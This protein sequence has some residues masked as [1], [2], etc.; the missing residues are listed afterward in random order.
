MQNQNKI[1]RYIPAILVLIVISLIG[2]TLWLWNQQFEIIEYDALS[3]KSKPRLNELYA[4]EIFLK[5]IHQTAESHS[6]A[7]YVVDHLPPPQDIIIYTNATERLSNP[8]RREALISWVK[9]GGHLV[10][11][12]LNNKSNDPLLA[13]LGVHKYRIQDYLDEQEESKDDDKDDK[14]SEPKN[15]SDDKTK[16]LYKAPHETK[17]HEVIRE[18]QL[19]ATAR[20]PKKSNQTE[21][22]NDPL[23]ENKSLQCSV[24]S[25]TT[26]IPRWGNGEKQCGLLNASQS[27][28]QNPIQIHICTD[29]YLYDDSENAVPSLIDKWGLPH[30]LTYSMGEGEI[31]VLDDYEFLTNNR[32]LYFDHAY[33]LS[34][35]SKER[36]KVW[37]IFE[38]NSE[39]LIPFL[40][41]HAKLA[42]LS[43]AALIGLYLW[44]NML[45]F[46]PAIAT[47][48]AARRQLI[49]HLQA[50]ATFKWKHEKNHAEISQIQH[51]I[52]MATAR[53][54]GRQTIDFE[55]DI[56]WLANA[57]QLSEEEIRSSLSTECPREPLEFVS[58]TKILFRLRTLL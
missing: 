38:G 20:K 13:D 16:P 31:K 39:S 32:I 3:G 24:P 6:S 14:S 10:I 30:I 40:W 44:R 34:Q 28:N 51:E 29:Y 41:K 56:A 43:F 46:G 36:N 7:N 23:H 19:A 25:L 55:K 27:L 47:P 54:Q 52:M 42:I 11:N 12:A 33:Y 37:L 35:L 5:K 17:I 22:K 45:R 48:S 58:L 49:E 26:P 50:S 2:Y 57:S 21:Q 15:N 1:S 8:V 9:S 53:K 4:A 18:K